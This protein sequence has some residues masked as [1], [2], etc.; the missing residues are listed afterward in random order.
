MITFVTGNK[1]KFLE[2]QKLVPELRQEKIDLDEI[3]AASAEEVITHKLE[4]GK[5]HLDGPFIVEDTGLEIGA[6]NGF[7]GPY[8]K[9]MHQITGFETIAKTFAGS[10]A[11]ATCTIGYFD[12]KDMH[13]VQGRCVGT[14]RYPCLQ[15]AFGFD[16]Y[17]VPEGETRFFGEMSTEEK[18]A[19]S[20]RGRAF[21]KLSELLKELSSN[22]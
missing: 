7:P 5:A 20:H 4:Q 16:R 3:Q 2:A 11:T 14:I 10:K 15:E 22:E 12:G 1:N 6:L 18:N 21:K 19:M 9:W 13:I 8:V 17:F